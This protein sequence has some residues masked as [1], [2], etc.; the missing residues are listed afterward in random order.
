MVDA[1][2]KVTC[3]VKRPK[4]QLDKESKTKF[5]IHNFQ[6]FFFFLPTKISTFYSF[7]KTFNF[8]LTFSHG[9]PQLNLN[10]SSIAL[11]PRRLGE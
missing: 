3:I 7:N 9:S 1:F 6:P 4:L 2:A 11:R 8:G 5:N 10:S